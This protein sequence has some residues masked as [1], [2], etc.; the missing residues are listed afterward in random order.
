MTKDERIAELENEIKKKDELIKQL[1]EANKF[2]SSDKV[3]SEEQC[4]QIA[5]EAQLKVMKEN[6]EIIYSTIRHEICEEIRKKAIFDDSDPFFYR[7]IYHIT[8]KL[9]DQIEKG[10]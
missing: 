3:V 5:R 6:I 10:E 9:L 8:P 7:P 4:K 2:L 1:G